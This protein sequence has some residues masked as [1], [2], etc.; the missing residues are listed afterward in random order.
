MEGVA[1]RAR[2]GKAALYRRW[3]SIDELALDTFRR[4]WPA[5]PELPANG[6]LRDDLIAIL[7]ELATILGGGPHPSSW[8][9]VTEIIVHPRIAAA[10]RAAVIEPRIDLTLRSLSAAAD[11]GEVRYEQVTPLVAR[12]G[13]ALVVQQHLIL[14]QP[15][16]HADVLEIVDRVWLPAA[17]FAG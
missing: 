15:P 2:T 12:L 17:R 6:S 11:R 14:G 13:S 10:F 5:L 16:S 8:M 3:P 1:A 9:V 4:A 7:A